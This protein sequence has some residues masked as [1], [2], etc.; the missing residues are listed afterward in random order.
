MHRVQFI[1][2]MTLDELARSIDVNI[3][4]SLQRE[5]G[6]VGQFIEKLLGASAGNKPEP[7]FIELGIELKTIPID[8]KGSPSESTYVCVV[9]LSHTE[10]LNWENSL[11]KT[12]LNHVLWIPIEADKNIHLAKR[13]VGMGILWKPDTEIEAELARDYDEFVDRISL[14]KVESITADQ[15]NLLQIR[16][17]A[18]NSSALTEG[19]GDQGQAIRTLPRG[20]YL[21]SSF[22][23]QIIS[24]WRNDFCHSKL[25]D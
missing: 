10:G 5:K 13:K 19:I 9:P 8:K 11:V 24:R 15:G 17:K 21:R 4:V 1:A 23:R 2:G 14:G 20:F 16:P 7:D 25:A 6:W 12:K 18:A 3:P 22:T